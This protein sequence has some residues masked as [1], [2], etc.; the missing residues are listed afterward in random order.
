MH[1][2]AMSSGG[3]DQAVEKEPAVRAGAERCTPVVATLDDVL[4][5]PRR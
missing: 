5:L 3:V 1:P 4:R 2:A